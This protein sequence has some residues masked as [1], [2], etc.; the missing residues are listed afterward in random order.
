MTPWECPRCGT[1][2]A[3]W[4]GRCECAPFTL[5]TAHAGLDSLK[6]SCN[7]AATIDI[8]S[9]Y[10]TCACPPL[11]ELECTRTQCPRQMKAPPANTQ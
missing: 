5:K 3:P 11:C 7:G 2:N 9:S 4:Q 8:R 10:Y 6:P 1:M